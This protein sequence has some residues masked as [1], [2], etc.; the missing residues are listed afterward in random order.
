[1]LCINCDRAAVWIFQTSGIGPRPYCDGH[2]PTAYRGTS[3]VKAAP[4]PDPQPVDVAVD[5]APAA[6]VKRRRK[7]AS[8]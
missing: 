1:M 7:T 3:W 4:K 5:E 2:L 6:P 8:E